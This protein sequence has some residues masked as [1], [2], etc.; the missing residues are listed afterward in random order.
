MKPRKHDLWGE[1]GDREAVA[2]VCSMI[3]RIVVHPTP[4]LFEVEGSLAALLGEAP[5]LEHSGISRCMPP[6]EPTGREAPRV[7]RSADESFVQ[8]SR[9]HK[10]SLTERYIVQ[11]RSRPPRRAAT[12]CAIIS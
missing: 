6:I 5:E 10:K 12:A 1:E 9:L 8:K 11:S 2:S 7:L 3:R 4:A